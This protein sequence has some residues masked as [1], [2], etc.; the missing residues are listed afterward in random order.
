[1]NQIKSAGAGLLD[2][3]LLIREINSIF[4]LIPQY[5]IIK[6]L[7]DHPDQ[8]RFYARL[9]SDLSGKYDYGNIADYLKEKG[10]FIKE[11]IKEAKREYS[12]LKYQDFFS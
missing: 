4:N 3:L 9:K 5:L 10:I 8:D 12:R 7:N 11:T 2:S 6:Y 1:M